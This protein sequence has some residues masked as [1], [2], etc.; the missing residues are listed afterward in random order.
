MRRRRGEEGK[1]RRGEEERKE[2]GREGSLS[3]LTEA[4]KP[5]TFLD[6]ESALVG[7]SLSRGS[8]CL[9]E[10]PGCH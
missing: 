2:G 8:L 5:H 6:L 7:L 4:R 1:K 3:F 9:R 10:V